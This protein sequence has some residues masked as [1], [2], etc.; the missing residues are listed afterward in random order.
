MLEQGGQQYQAF[1]YSKGSLL[2]DIKELKMIN[3]FVQCHLLLW[4][5]L[6]IEWMKRLARD[7]LQSVNATN[8]LQV[9]SV[10]ASTDDEPDAALLLLPSAWHQ[11]AGRVILPRK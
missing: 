4:P 1:P 9:A 3:M 8:V 6:K 5:W 7:F 11:A 2:C 10:G